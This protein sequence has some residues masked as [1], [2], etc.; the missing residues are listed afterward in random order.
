MT[1]PLTTSLNAISFIPNFHRFND[2][3]LL[4]TEIPRLTLLSGYETGTLN[5][6]MF[7][8]CHINISFQQCQFYLKQYVR[9]VLR[10]K[11]TFQFNDSSTISYILLKVHVF[12]DSLS[13]GDCQFT[14]SNKSV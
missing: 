9:L 13:L 7:K 12:Q 4:Q 6:H 14:C 10:T 3:E 11:C 5:K 2:L 1:E 8:I